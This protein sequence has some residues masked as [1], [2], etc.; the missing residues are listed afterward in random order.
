LTVPP[1]AP[2]DGSIRFEDLKRNLLLE[3]DPKSDFELFLKVQ[4]ERCAAGGNAVFVFT[5]EGSPLHR[6]LEGVEGVSL[7]LLSLDIESSA[8]RG[9]EVPGRV[10]LLSLDKAHFLTLL[11]SLMATKGRVYV[12]LDSVT[13]MVMALGF[14]ETYRILRQS[15]EI[16][17][18]SAGTRINAIVVMIKGTQSLSEANTFRS[19]FQVIL[20]YDSSGL[21]ALKPPDMKISWAHPEPQTAAAG[22]RTEDAPEKQTR[23][24]VKGFLGSLTGRSE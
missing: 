3:V 9:K 20:T 23:G 7:V 19:M 16:V 11:D 17:G 22:V 12:F 13:S 14:A 1:P 4:A 2:S 8:Q 10:A 24:G 18:R 21:R 5:S 6:L 15:I